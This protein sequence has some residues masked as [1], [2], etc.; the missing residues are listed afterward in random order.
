MTWLLA[1]VF[2]P[3]AALVLFGL[4]CLPARMAVQRWMPQGRLKSLLL[5]RVGKGWGAHRHTGR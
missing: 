5:L 4:I 3:L 2:R 1:V